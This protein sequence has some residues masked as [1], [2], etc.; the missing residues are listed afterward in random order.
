MTR[1]L[2][3]LKNLRNHRSGQ[4]CMSYRKDQSIQKVLSDYEKLQIPILEIK[5]TTMTDHQCYDCAWLSL[6]ALST[7]TCNLWL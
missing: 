2:R 3:A 4:I 7:V 6:T 5:G 1:Y